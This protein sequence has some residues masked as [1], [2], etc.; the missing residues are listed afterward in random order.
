ME[1][2]EACNPDAWTMMCVKNDIKKLLATDG[3]YIWA[4]AEMVTH[5]KKK[6]KGKAQYLLCPRSFRR[7]KISWVSIALGVACGTFVHV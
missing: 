2:I 4:L 7:N 5:K 1:I 3:G 6:R